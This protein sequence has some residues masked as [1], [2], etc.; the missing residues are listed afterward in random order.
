MI[1]F[2]DGL[3]T[4]K[5]RGFYKCFLELDSSKSLVYTCTLESFNFDR[6]AKSHKD[7][8]LAFA[9]QK[10]IFCSRGWMKIL[11]TSSS[12]V[13]MEWFKDTCIPKSLKK[14]FRK[15]FFRELLDLPLQCD[16]FLVDCDDLKISRIQGDGK[17]H[18]AAK[19]HQI[20]TIFG[21]VLACPNRK[22]PFWAQKSF[23]G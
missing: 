18:T 5:K 3:A 11:V 4:L 12:F 22:P 2:S 23:R 17:Q 8:H 14:N 21:L 1:S 7:F 16:S 15:G 6:W 13:K 20:S 19:F 10:T 9:P